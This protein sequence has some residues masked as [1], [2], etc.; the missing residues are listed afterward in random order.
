MNGEKKKLAAFDYSKKPGAVF[1]NIQKILAGSFLTKNF[2][3]V[4]PVQE[5]FSEDVNDTLRKEWTGTGGVAAMIG[6][7][8]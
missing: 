2:D 6:A 1:T 8:L 7:V 4:V 5:Q 3:Q